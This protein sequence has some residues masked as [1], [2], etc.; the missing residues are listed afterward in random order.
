VCQHQTVIR[1]LLPPLLG[2][3][4][5]VGVLAWG[6]RRVLPTLG[7]GLW[8]PADPF[9]NGDFNGGWWLWWASHEAVGGAPGWE[10][11]DWPQGVASLAAVIPNPADM[12]FL[13]LFGAPTVLAWN[14]VQLFHLVAVLVATT[15][16]AR[17]AGAGWWAAGAGVSL[18]AAS[19]ILLHEVA[20]GRPSNLI[21][22]PGLLALAALCRGRGVAAGLLAAIQ[23]IAYAWH[24]LALV[25]VGLPLVRS[26]RPAIVAAITGAVVVAPY[27]VWLVAG[28]GEVPTD[29]PQVG[30]THLAGAGIFGLESVPPRFRLHPFLLGAA[31]LGLRSGWRF[32]LAGSIG[33]LLAMGPQ[34]EWTLGHPLTTGPFAWLQWAV[35]A[36]NRMHHPLR[37]TLLA[38]PLLCVAASLGLSRV[39]GGRLLA[40]GLVFSAL[41]FDKPMDEATTYDQPGVPDF[42]DLEAPGQ[43][44]VVDLLGMHH[45][46]ALAL[47]TV[48][49][50]PLLEPLW[51]QRPRT[52][53]QAGVERLVRTGTVP[54]G[55][56]Q[57]L[58]DQGFVQVWALDRF[59]SGPDLSSVL[60]ADLGPPLKPGVYALPSPSL[61]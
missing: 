38:V 55:L 45:R 35:P 42:A 15:V 20:G 14:L 61:E 1:R 12:L 11:L 39:R 60:E 8:G 17:A 4:L 48:H 30:Y 53:V 6:L 22:W 43:G 37:A 31:L 3:L 21:V 52:G 46:T 13:G 10:R 36:V 26:V 9:R 28:I 18:L 57:V 33:L 58:S 54:S 44:P 34:L 32:A 16:L 19:P 25:W 2:S 27:I 56:W 5:P 50:R 41:W 29:T 23:G 40:I 47:Q 7:T 59:G 51:F 24:G 49:G